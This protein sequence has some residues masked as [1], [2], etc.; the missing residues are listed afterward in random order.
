MFMDISKIMIE[1]IIHFLWSMELVIPEV[2]VAECIE[3]QQDNYFNTTIP[4]HC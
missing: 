1:N 4:E 2:G 3:I